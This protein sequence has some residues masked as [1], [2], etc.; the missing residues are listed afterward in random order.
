MK[1]RP[2]DMGQLQVGGVYLGNGK[3]DVDR[4]S[5]GAKEKHTSKRE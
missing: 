2:R 4:M 5:S 1:A 3:S